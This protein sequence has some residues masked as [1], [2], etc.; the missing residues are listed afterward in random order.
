MCPAVYANSIYFVNLPVKLA[1]NSLKLLLGNDVI[2]C[3]FYQ[4][5]FRSV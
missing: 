1:V 4:R 2:R 5:F 3:R